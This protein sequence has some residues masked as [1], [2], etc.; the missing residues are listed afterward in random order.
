MVGLVISE[1]LKFHFYE[2]VEITGIFLP[3]TNSKFAPK[4]DGPSKFGISRLPGVYFQVFYVSF[5]LF[6]IPL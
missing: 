3:K 1:S 6:H 4:N 5:R 2:L